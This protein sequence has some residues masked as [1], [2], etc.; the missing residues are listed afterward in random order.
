MTNRLSSLTIKIANF[1]GR[2]TFDRIFQEICRGKKSREKLKRMSE[3]ER[4][5]FTPKELQARHEK[6]AVQQK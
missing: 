3:H 1:F 5:D 2:P 4:L 6:K